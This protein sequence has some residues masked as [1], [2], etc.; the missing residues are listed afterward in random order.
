MLTNQIFLN[1]CFFDSLDNGCFHRYLTH[2][3]KICK[4]IKTEL[5]K[6]KV[7]V[8]KAPLCKSSEKTELC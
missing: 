8:Y 6:G 7:R 3:S 5:C 4:G 1:N 2:K